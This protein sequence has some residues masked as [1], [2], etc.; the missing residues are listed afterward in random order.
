M[1]R[2]AP[3][4]KNDRRYTATPLIDVCAHSDGVG[5]EKREGLEKAHMHIPGRP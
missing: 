3:E 2:G 4:I 1:P 5:T